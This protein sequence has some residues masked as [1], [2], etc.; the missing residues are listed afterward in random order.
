MRI[1][2]RTISESN[3]NPA[4]HRNVVVEG[5]TPEQVVHLLPNCFIVFQ[6]TEEDYDGLFCTSDSVLN[7]LKPN[8]YVCNNP[9]DFDKTL[10]KSFD[11]KIISL[12][13]LITVTGLTIQPNE[14][15][16]EIGK[17]VQNNDDDKFVIPIKEEVQIF[18][19]AIRYFNH[20]TGEDDD[21]KTV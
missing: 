20:S 2:I 1:S 15:V 8:L 16:P 19:T 4:G 11:C 3:I 14:P 13:E 18:E 7:V 12:E 6:N 17:F 10:C 9:T 21:S 5:L